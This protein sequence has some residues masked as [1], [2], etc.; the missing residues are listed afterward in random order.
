MPA[1]RH[2]AAL[3]VLLIPGLAFDPLTGRLWETGNGDNGNDEVNLAATGVQQ[4]LLAGDEEGAAGGGG[5]DGSDGFTRRGGVLRPGAYVPVG[6]VADGHRV[7][8]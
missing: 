3:F 6:G 2:V 7:P 1:L 8:G 5:A 4:R